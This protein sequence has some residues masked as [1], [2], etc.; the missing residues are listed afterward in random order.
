MGD[1]LF[2]IEVFQ[3]HSAIFSSSVNCNSREVAVVSEKWE[4]VV[5][6]WLLDAV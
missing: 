5:Y 4:D 6:Y 1:A 2:G 3:L